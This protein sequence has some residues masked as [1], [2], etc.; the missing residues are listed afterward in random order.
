MLLKLPQKKKQK[1]KQ[2]KISKKVLKGTV[3]TVPFFMVNC[4][5]K[6]VRELAASR[7]ELRH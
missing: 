4:T 2:K 6:V 5:T 3:V 1:K 7:R